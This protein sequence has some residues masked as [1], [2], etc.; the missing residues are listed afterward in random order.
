MPIPI[1]WLFAASQVVQQPQTTPTPDSTPPASVASQIAAP[2]G[3]ALQPAFLDARHIIEVDSAPPAQRPRVIEFTHAYEVRL[4]I[5]HYASYA[6]LP[7][8][9]AEFVLGQQL[10]NNPPGSSS[11]LRAHQLVALSV[12]GLFGVNTITGA[13]NL[14]D[15]RKNPEGRLKRWIHAGLMMASDAGFVATGV[16][17]PSR[18]KVLNDPAAS[19]L[20]RTI[21]IASIGTALAGYGMMLLWKD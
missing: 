20:H 15:S 11:T 1:V 17:A 8:F 10:Y 3:P 16:T 4:T 9:A 12:A 6:T 18:R 19:R 7:L 14:W 13:W 2:L 5:H 21:A